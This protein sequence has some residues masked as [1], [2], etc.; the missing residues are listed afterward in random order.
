[1]LKLY[2]IEDILKEYARQDEL[3]RS[4]QQPEQTVRQE[5]EEQPS[6]TVPEPPE[7]I[8]EEESPPEPTELPTQDI[9]EKKRRSRLM[10]LADRYGYFME[11][12]IKRDFKARYQGTFFGVLWRFGRKRRSS[13]RRPSPNRP[14]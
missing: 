14:K 7:M 5:T 9:P 6:Q 10:Q 13:P 8:P 3:I 2:T 4:R 11:Q 12:L 1:M